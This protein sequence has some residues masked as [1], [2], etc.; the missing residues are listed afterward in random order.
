MP[1]APIPPELPE[2]YEPVERVGRGGIGE[3]WRVRDRNL[4]R[5]LA[6]KLLRRDR[7]TGPGPTRR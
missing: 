6:V 4:D 1:A 7:G 5:D 3:V 2:R